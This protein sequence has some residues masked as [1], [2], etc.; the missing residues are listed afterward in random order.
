MSGKMYLIHV[1]I[2]YEMWFECS[3]DSAQ[4]SPTV[5]LYRGDVVATCYLFEGSD[6][7]MTHCYI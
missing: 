3:G 5:S 1:E 4:L 7:Y 2:I 6:T